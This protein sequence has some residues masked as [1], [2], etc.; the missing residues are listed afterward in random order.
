[1]WKYFGWKMVGGTAARSGGFLVCLNNMWVFIN[2]L[3]TVANV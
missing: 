3:K 1:M 2:I